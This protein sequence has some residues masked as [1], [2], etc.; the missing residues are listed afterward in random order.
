[1]SVCRWSNEDYTCPVYVYGTHD[2]V[3][4]TH[5]AASRPVWAEGVL[6]PKVNEEPDPHDAEGYMAWAT[7]FGEVT[8]LV[9]EQP[10]EDLNLPYDGQ[11][12]EH[13]TPAACADHLEHM[14][15][16]GYEIPQYAI[17]ALRAEE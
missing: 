15:S 2:D 12:F 8:R 10:R 9:G 5:V 14:R 1:M 17:D 6:P 11:T 13:N 7:R 3:W 16:V 4:V